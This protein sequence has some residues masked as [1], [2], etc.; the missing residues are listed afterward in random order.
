M[1]QT[2]FYSWKHFMIA[3]KVF[4]KKEKLIAEIWQTSGS[5]NIMMTFDYSST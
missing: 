5:I 4:N 1:F 2:L 3:S